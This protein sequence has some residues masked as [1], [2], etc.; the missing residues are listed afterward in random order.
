MKNHRRYSYAGIGSRDTPEEIL[1]I[2]TYIS[3]TLAANYMVL[4][5]GG[6]DGADRAFELGCDLSNGTK[7]IYI[8]WEGFNG[9]SRTEAMTYAELTDAALE[10]ASKFHPAW[11]R[12]SS[13]ARRLHA[14]N[15]YQILSKHLNDPCDFVVCWTPGAKATGG[16]GQ[17]IRIAKHYGI[18][19]FD[20]ADPTALKGLDVFLTRLTG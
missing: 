11:D 9:R 13:G 6:A 17:A 2:M 8:P 15:C 5:S 4:R 16:T 14:R 20:L 19:I 7:E 12:C 10:L 3:T 1:S 18:P